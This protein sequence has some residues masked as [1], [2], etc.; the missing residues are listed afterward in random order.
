MNLMDALKKLEQDDLKA[1]EWS[2]WLNHVLSSMS[3]VVE[4][5]K[6]TKFLVELDLLTD[7]LPD[8]ANEAVYR[9]N[10]VSCIEEVLS[11][12]QIPLTLE[13]PRFYAWRTYLVSIRLWFRG[14]ILGVMQWLKR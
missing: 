5:T 13:I 2:T 3:N 1:L 9:L 14:I 7:K 12:T 4:E 8:I 10:F 6:M 11:I